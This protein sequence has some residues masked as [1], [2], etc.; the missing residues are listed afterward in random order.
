MKQTNKQGNKQVGEREGKEQM[1]EPL[2]IWFTSQMA[3]TGVGP[4]QEW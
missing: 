3:A 2:T 4:D 1:S